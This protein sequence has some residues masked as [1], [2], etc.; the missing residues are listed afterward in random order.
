MAP[1]QSVEHTFASPGS[2]PYVCSLHPT[3]MTGSVLVTGA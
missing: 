2:Y 3:D 1:G